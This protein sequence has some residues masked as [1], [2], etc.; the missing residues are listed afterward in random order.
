M[1]QDEASNESAPAARGAIQFICVAE[2]GTFSLLPEG[3]EFFRSLRGP[4][5]I[6]AV[7]GRMRSGKSYLMNSLS[8]GRAAFQVS[9]LVDACTKGIWVS[10][11][12]Q[13]EGA[14]PVVFMDTEGLFSA[15]RDTTVDSRLFALTLLLASYFIYNGGNVIDRNALERMSV[16]VHLTNYVHVRARGEGEGESGSEFREHFPHFMWV[17]RD[18]SLGMQHEGQTPAQY[19]EAQLAANA[20][21]AQDARGRP[22]AGAVGRALMTFFPN[23]DCVL[24]PT[25]LADEGDMAELPTLPADRLRPDFVRGL[26]ELRETVMRNATAKSIRGRPL[27]GG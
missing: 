19:L 2:D 17:A 12:V 1:G 8:R 27:A 4:V 5:A 3:V 24:L 14:P 18:F 15:D 23:R 26:D 16:V 10:P 9:P 25:P 13:R 11:P 20:D 7:A 6:V 21:E 22:S